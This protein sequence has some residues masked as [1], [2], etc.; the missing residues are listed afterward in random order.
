MIV[1]GLISLGIIIVVFLLLFPQTILIIGI[2]L[3]VP[4]RSEAPELYTIPTERTVS[5]T[6]SIKQPL[7]FTLGNLSFKVP[8]K[9]LGKKN[10][11]G[12]GKYT[13]TNLD[14]ENNKSILNLGSTV[15]TLKQIFEDPSPEEEKNL[16]LLYQEE[17]LDSSFHFYKLVYN[18]SP[19]QLTL[20]TGAKKGIVTSLLVTY[21]VLLLTGTGV[22]TMYSFSTD[23]TQG[24]QIGDP[25]SDHAASLQFF[26]KNDLGYELVI[27][28]ATQ[29]E[30][31]FIIQS[32]KTQ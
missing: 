4:N 24:F 32:I 11:A 29:A 19:D 23:T 15:F 6:I 16:R 18:S 2:K 31:D 12:S 7:E 22:H 27:R 1:L 26:D 10:V 17:N 9:T 25:A 21:K 5:N 30:I 20:F 28:G 8:W 3:N 13:L 14:F